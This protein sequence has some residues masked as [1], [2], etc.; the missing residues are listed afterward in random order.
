MLNDLFFRLRALFRRKTVETEL[1]DELRFHFEFN[2]QKYEN[3]GLTREE[4]LRRARLEF[5][6]IGQVKEECRE[7]RGV[8]F[9]EELFQDVRYGLRMLR[10]SPGFAAVALLTL[11]LGIGANTAIFSVVYGVLLRSLPYQD[12][13]GLVVLN[14]T[15]PRIG[16]VSVSYPN[17]LDWRSGNRSF[18]QMAA[19]ASVSFNLG[20]VDQPENINGEAV[21]PNFLSMLGVRPIL[22]RDFDASE[23]KAGTAPVVL[24][25]YQ[26]WQSHLGG[27][28]GALGRTINLDGKSFTIIGVLP[29]DF[30]SIDKTDIMVPIGVWL[31]GNSDANS[32]G[33]RGDM[34]AIGR[35]GPGVSF[36]QAQAEMQAIAA[37]LAAAYPG[38]N[39]QFS[40]ALRPIREVFVGEIRPA[41]LILFG[42]VL[43]VLLIACA[44]VANLFLMR[45]AARTREIA[46]RIALGATRG[47]I[48]RQMLAESFVL[49]F[50]GG[51]LG[52]AV[53][54]AGIRGLARLIPMAGM[55]GGAVNMNGT[56][57]L[58]AA[59]AVVASAFLFG[60]VPAMNLTKPDVQPELKEGGRSASSGAG[61]NRLRGL[62]AAGEVAVALILLVGA[63]LMMKSLYR[64]L[65]VDPG[66]KTDR[67]LTMDM[68]LRT[69]QYA[70]DPAVL[71]FWQQVLYRVRALPGVEAAALGTVVP[72]T[73]SH[74]R[75]DIT[76]EGMALPKPGSFPHPDAHSVSPG[77]LRTLGVPLLR[78]REFTDADQANSPLVGMVNAAIA[79][80]FFPNQD[81]L[82]KR[83]MFGHPKADPPRWI[84]IVGIAADTKLYGLANPARLEVYLPLRQAVSS[85]M[86]LIVKSAADPAA[87]TSSIRGA[88]ASIDKDQPIFAIA[89]MQELV[90]S[91]ISTRRITLILLGL[92][93]A[94]ALVLA[95]IGIYGVIS[96]SVAQRTHEIG[97][98]MALGADGGGVLRMI[99]AQGVKIAGAGVAI[100]ILASFGLTR[101]MTKLLYSVSAADP[102]TF[103]AV[104]IVLVLV[105]MLACY[106]P[107]RRALRVDPIIALRYE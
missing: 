91:S 14:E 87:L 10:K 69:A 55:A 88:I 18:S 22:G 61:Q 103:A 76:I 71:N 80:Q 62:L 78:G 33:D 42:A 17:F 64:L 24:L 12:P 63:G 104:A 4:A 23:E 83:F 47:R 85:G 66:F 15:T 107:A 105:A 90:N 38:T 21:S 26:L 57:L 98:R 8:H 27:G 93:S 43:F 84:T 86:N 77:Y 36:A 79:R 1:D 96:Y 40:A 92:F 51:L 52:V 95:A 72:F 31:T 100:G 67:I 2:V 30:V 106:I 41:I 97:I 9:M 44:N 37:R 89:T 54:I 58:F 68:Q 28:L 94:L 39:D 11:A 25:S 45:G 3:L 74:S 35:L 48:I 6:G 60:L 53:S 70:K 20:G 56:V 50:F 49:A 16:T 82:G 65:A 5:G 99:L 7:A 46:L 19:V 75:A 73:D 101:L 29:P 59:A 81:V 102:V 32:R 13:G 34:A